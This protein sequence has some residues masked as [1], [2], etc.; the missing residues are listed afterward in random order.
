MSRDEHVD[1]RLKLAI[2]LF[3][4][5]CSSGGCLVLDL[6]LGD[7]VSKVSY[8]VFKLRLSHCRRRL[9]CR[10]GAAVVLESLVQGQESRLKF[11]HANRSDRSGREILDH[12]QLFLAKSPVVEHADQADSAGRTSQRIKRVRIG[13]VTGS[14]ALE[15]EERVARVF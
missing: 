4:M 14:A 7:L 15:T 2:L 11:C 1:P 9:D 13:I 12:P 6:K 10:R 8:C 3:K 5:R